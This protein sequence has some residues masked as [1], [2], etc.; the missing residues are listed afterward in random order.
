MENLNS[1]LSDVFSPF[2]SSQMQLN[3]CISTY[4]YIG[5]HIGKYLQV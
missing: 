5:K 3:Q 4:F 2:A 1:Y